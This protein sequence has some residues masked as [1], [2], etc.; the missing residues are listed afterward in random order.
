MMAANLPLESQSSG[1]ENFAVTTNPWLRKSFFQEY[2]V[3]TATPVSRLIW[4]TLWL[5]G[6]IIFLTICSLNCGP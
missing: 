3:G 4:A 5:C 6:G 1:R 2:K